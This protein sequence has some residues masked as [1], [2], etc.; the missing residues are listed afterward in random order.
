MGLLVAGLNAIRDFWS[1]LIGRFEVGIGTDQETREDTS[2]QEVHNTIAS[3]TKTATSQ[4]IV[5]SSCHPS[6]SSDS[7]S[8]IT[9]CGWGT[10]SLLVSRA[11]FPEVVESTSYDIDIETRWFFKGR[12]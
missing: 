10:S 12:F 11:T 1:D 6:T 7:G 8:A 9:E 4:N 3:V 2:L 5:I